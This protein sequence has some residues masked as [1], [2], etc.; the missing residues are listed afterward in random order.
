MNKILEKLMSL[1][2]TV[3][4]GATEVIELATEIKSEAQAAQLWTDAH[5]TALQAAVQTVAQPVADA[6]EKN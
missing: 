4:A 2:P 3:E 6:P 5:E 1:L